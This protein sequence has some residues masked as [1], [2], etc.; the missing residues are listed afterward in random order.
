MTVKSDRSI[1]SLFFAFLYDA[2]FL[3]FC[4]NVKNKFKN[5]AGKIILAYRKLKNQLR[6]FCN[7]F[8]ENL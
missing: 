3:P 7:L 6:N 1:S 5:V 2:A 4:E 8:I